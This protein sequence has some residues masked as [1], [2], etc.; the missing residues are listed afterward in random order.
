MGWYQP[1]VVVVH[2]T[3][4][5]ECFPFLWFWL[6]GLAF[7]FNCSSSSYR[8]LIYSSFTEWREWYLTALKCI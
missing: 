4:L 2:L 8:S 1:F 3:L 5:S 7:A 6:L